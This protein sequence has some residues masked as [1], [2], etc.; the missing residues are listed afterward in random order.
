MGFLD[1]LS[2]GLDR[3][4]ETLETFGSDTLRATKDFSQIQKLR[5]EAAD[6]K[7]AVNTQYLRLGRKYYEEHKDDP[8]YAEDPTM[9]SIAQNLKKMKDCER[10]IEKL[11]EDSAA[12]KSETADAQAAAEA[13]RTVDAEERAAR[14]Q[15]ERRSAQEVDDDVV[16]YKP[17]DEADFADD[18]DFVDEE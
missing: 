18:A 3:L 4:G 11:K 13:A 7:R 1:D 15:E 5:G 9:I 14:Q 16:D 10:E 12:S 17:V 6:A 8:A 2:G